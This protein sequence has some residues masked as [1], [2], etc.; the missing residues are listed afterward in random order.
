MLA[1]ASGLKVSLVSSAVHFSADM[2]ALWPNDAHPTHLFVCDES[3]SNPGVQRV[4]LAGPP[5]ANASTIARCTRFS[6][7][8]RSPR[9][10]P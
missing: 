2:I 1:V 10:W 5:N 7:R 3:S 4:D 6:S 9:R 8:I